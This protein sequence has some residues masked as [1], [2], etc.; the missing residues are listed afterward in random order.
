M[1]IPTRAVLACRAEAINDQQP[2]D[3]SAVDLGGVWS[4]VRR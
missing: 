4:I 3:R 2:G 1:I